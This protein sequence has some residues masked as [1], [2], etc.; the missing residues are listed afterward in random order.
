VA[1][2]TEPDWLRVMYVVI[3]IGSFDN[4]LVSPAWPVMFEHWFWYLSALHRTTAQ[5]SASTLLNHY[6]DSHQITSFQSHLQARPFKMGPI[7]C[8][9]TSVTNYQYTLCNIPEVHN[10]EEWKKLLRTA[11]NRRILHMPME[12]TNEHPRRRNVICT[13]VKPWNH[14]RMPIQ[15]CVA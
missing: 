13:V 11:R 10:R 3:H 6:I 1:A 5:L 9:E 14:A 15:S 4:S 8:S 2:L 12:W 7:R